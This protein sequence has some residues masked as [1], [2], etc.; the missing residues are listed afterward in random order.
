MLADWYFCDDCKAI[1]MSEDVHVIVHR[2]VHYWL[3]DQPVETSYEYLC[4][5]CGSP[6]ISEAAY[7]EE[8]GEVC[9]P[10]DLD[11]NWLCAEC[12]KKYEEEEKQEE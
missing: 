2:D 12:R 6:C 4:P 1:F 9:L 8:C 3:D 5:E 11:E 7:C 10:E